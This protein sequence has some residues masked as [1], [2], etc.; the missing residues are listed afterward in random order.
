MLVLRDTLCDVAVN[1]SQRAKLSSRVVR[2]S[3]LI[4]FAIAGV[5]CRGGGSTMT[6][7][8]DPATREL[9]RLDYDINGDGRIDVRT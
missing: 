3:V 8:Y 2:R 5:A 6:P 1:V 9:I 4:F 7:I